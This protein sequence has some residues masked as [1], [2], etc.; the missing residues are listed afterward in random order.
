MPDPCIVIDSST[1]TPVAEQRELSPAASLHRRFRAGAFWSLIGGVFSRGPVLAA[2]VACARLLGTRGFGE[3]GILQSTAGM[4]GIFAGL[5]L[6][7]TATKYVAE[8]RGKDPDRAGRV[9]AISAVTALISGILMTGTLILTA[10]FLAKHTLGAPNLA[11]PLAIA[12]GL[13][14]FGAM[15]GAQNGALI[16][17]EAF[18]AIARVNLWT[19]LLSLVFIVSGAKY[20]GLRGAVWGL[21]GG[22]AANWLLNNRAIRYACAEARISYQFATCAKEWRILYQFSLPAFLASVVVGP[23]MWACNALLVN[24]RDGYLEMG[25]YTAA[26]KWRLLILFIPGTVAGIAL[27]M[28]SNLHGED[29]PSGYSKV[30]NANVLL[31]LGLTIL[32]GIVIALFAVPILSVYGTAYRSAWPILVILAFSAVPEALNNVFGYAA[33]SQGGVWWRLGFDVLLA[34]ALVGFSFWAIPKWGAVGLAGG[35]CVALSLSSI[36]LFFYLRSRFSKM[37]SI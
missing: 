9:L 20:G 33:I 8:F 23:A 6:G 10:S 13:V 31:N 29:D 16:G 24:Q 15:N 1:L 18:Q 7:L 27:P 21:I 2:S 26:D 28:L 35:Y 25:L 14:F 34:V 4:F 19:G 36:G 22:V 12:S 11:A 37:A 5:G 32:P 17:L 30:F 3:F